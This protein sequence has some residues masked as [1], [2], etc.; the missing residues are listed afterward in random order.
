MTNKDRERLLEQ[1]FKEHDIGSSHT[2]FDRIDEWNSVGIYK[3]MHDGNLPFGSDA[4]TSILW[5]TEFLDKTKTDHRFVS[6]MR[7]QRY[8]IGTLQPTAKRLVYKFADKIIN[9]KINRING[10][11]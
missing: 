3:L 2:T 8:K 10:N 4:D 5:I 9:E 7:R 6:E 11:Q 1:L